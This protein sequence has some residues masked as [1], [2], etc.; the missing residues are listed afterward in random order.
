MTLFFKLCVLL[1]AIA[2]CFCEPAYAAGGLDKVNHFMD[3]ITGILRGAA[4]ATVTLAIMWAGYKLLFT[5]ANPMEVGKIVI[6][7]MLIGGAA[8]I[9][10]YIISQ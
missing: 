6:A 9:A 8:E 4:I 2:C 10:R 7:G 5:Q 3:S 1:V